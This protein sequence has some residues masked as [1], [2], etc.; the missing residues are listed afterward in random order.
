MDPCLHETSTYN[1]VF[2][3]HVLMNATIQYYLAL[4]RYKSIT[5]STCFN[6]IMRKHD[7]D[8]GMIST[9]DIEASIIECR[10]VV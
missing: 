5:C 6:F 4:A 3:N 7:D 10:I 9:H 8:D 2:N 1:D